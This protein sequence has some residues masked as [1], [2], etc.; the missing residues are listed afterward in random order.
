MT[1]NWCLKIELSGHE[2]S[3][4]LRVSNIEWLSGTLAPCSMTSST[5]AWIL[6]TGWMNHCVSRLSCET[7]LEKS[8]VGGLLQVS[9]SSSMLAMTLLQ[10]VQHQHRLAVQVWCLLEAVWHHMEAVQFR[11]TLRSFLLAS[12]YNH[13][14]WL[15]TVVLRMSKQSCLRYWFSCW[16]WLKYV[17]ASNCSVRGQVGCRQSCAISTGGYNSPG[18]YKPHAGGYE[19]H[20]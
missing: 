8:H 17:I 10:T 15:A 18:G 14:Q 16:V 12:W 13:L 11:G 6:W 7:R 1:F 4:S 5:M 3:C 20:C 2:I 19:S 9:G